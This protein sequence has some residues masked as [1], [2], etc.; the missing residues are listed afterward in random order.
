MN[1]LDLLAPPPYVP[2][3]GVG[4]VHRMNDPR[5]EL[6]MCRSCGQ[7]LPPTEFYYSVGRGGYS[8]RCKTCDKA[9][10][11]ANKRRK[12]N[13]SVSTHSGEKI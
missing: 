7:E 12:R 11:M 3:L 2:P 8:P 9:V 10:S 5:D 4:R 6:F 13:E 1:L